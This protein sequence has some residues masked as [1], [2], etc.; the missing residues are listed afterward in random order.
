[1]ARDAVMERAA[2]R[3]A[4]TERTMPKVSGLGGGNIT[5]EL[6]TGHWRTSRRQGYGAHAATSPRRFGVK[7]SA[8]KVADTYTGPALAGQ[9][10][11]SDYFKE[12]RAQGGVCQL[13]TPKTRMQDSLFRLCVA[14]IAGEVLSEETKQRMRDFIEKIIATDPEHGNA[15]RL[16]MGIAGLYK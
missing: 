6:S 3:K 7:P 11:G 13:P 14:F 16:A 4:S 10:D 12:W 2:E 5:G 8:G 15:W 1:M 9:D